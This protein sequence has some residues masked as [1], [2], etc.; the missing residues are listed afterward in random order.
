M[1]TSE[2]GTMKTGMEWNQVDYIE[3]TGLQFYGFHGALSEENQLGQRFIVHLRLGLNLRPAGQTD[4][5][6][7]TVDYA[8]VYQAVRGIVEG[9][10]VRLIERVA[11]HIAEVL[12]DQFPL[13]ER[14]DVTVEKPGAPI[15]GVFG[16]VAVHIE[17]VR[18][19]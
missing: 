13:I 7:H 6:A 9:A 4:G 19:D 17:R 5:L 2:S 10:S 1:G 18:E 8:K 12:L 3:L 14:V 16:N 15:P 11:E